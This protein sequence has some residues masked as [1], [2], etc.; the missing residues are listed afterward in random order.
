MVDAE[1]QPR[2]NVPAEV[3]E[4]FVAT[5][6]FADSKCAVWASLQRVLE[7]ALKKSAEDRARIA[8]VVWGLL[9]LFGTP[10]R[11]GE[12]FFGQEQDKRGYRKARKAFSGL[13]GVLLASPM[14]ASLYKSILTRMPDDI[15]PH[16]SHPVMAVDFCF[17]A[18]R[19][20]GICALLSLSSLFIINT[21]LNVEVPEFYPKLYALLRPEQFVARHRSQLFQLTDMFLSSE[22]LP[23][24]VAASFAK[25]LAQLALLA[26]APGSLVCLQL[27][28]NLVRRNPNLM[29]MLHR[30]EEAVAPR[31][32]WRRAEAIDRRNLK[33]KR[34][35]T[36]DSE[37]DDVDDYVP[38]REPAEREPEVPEAPAPILVPE[39]ED[40]DAPRAHR[41]PMVLGS[42]GVS[43]G[44][45]VD[46]F[47]PLQEDP[48]LTGALES[49]LWEI[50]ALQ[51]HYW[52]DVAELAAS[53][54]G[55]FDRPLFDVEKASE[56]GPAA[57]VDKL[58]RKKAKNVPLE[59]RTK[60]KLLPDELDQAFFG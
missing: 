51:K 34:E 16:L 35:R 10:D 29:C 12:T 39:E 17:S 50:E 55:K 32:R 47:D 18:Y 28:F 43:A 24:V 58:R 15:L 3:Y 56:L 40:E 33:Q 1:G 49:S 30:E 8:Q 19:H 9:E 11:K 44:P 46:T 36:E 42:G 4:V 21:R 54:A 5:F 7:D 31:R 6:G 26:P 25:R 59:F 20:G 57:V 13:W 23:L 2:S 53:F 37:G 41:V 38:V 22:Y 48:A 52:K 60:A 45:F 14:S 27:V